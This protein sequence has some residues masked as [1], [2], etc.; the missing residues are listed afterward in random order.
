MA[1]AVTGG[2]IDGAGEFDMVG[3]SQG[4]D[5]GG[6][7]ARTLTDVGGEMGLLLG[8]VDDEVGDVVVVVDKPVGGFIQYCPLSIKLLL[9]L[10]N[11]FSIEVAL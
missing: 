1:I 7:V 10:V 6:G 3:P 5:D 2:G 4:P 8:I 11:H 9:D